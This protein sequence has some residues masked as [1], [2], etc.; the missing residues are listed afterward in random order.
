VKKEINPFQ[1]ELEV[2]MLNNARGELIRD[3]DKAYKTGNSRLISSY[4]HS[5]L[6][7]LKN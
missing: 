6:I 7:H 1:K 4:Q 2:E 5:L 3:L